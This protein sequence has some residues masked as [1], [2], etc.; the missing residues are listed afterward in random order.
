ME[1][2]VLSGTEL[3]GK[4]TSPFESGRFTA[5]IALSNAQQQTLYFNPSDTSYGSK[6]ID[7]MSF[8]F[9]SGDTFAG[10]IV[11]KTRK[12][13]KLF[14]A[15]PYYEFSW[16]D[17]LYFAYEVGFGSKGLFICLYDGEELIAVVDKQ[18]RVV[19]FKDTYTAYMANSKYTTIVIP[20]MIYYDVTAY[21]D[22]M[23]RAVLSVHKKNVTTLQKELI[24]K[25]D[26]DFIPR[27]K[28]L[29]GITD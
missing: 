29:E 19:N 16:N 3:V 21:G 23:E 18:L 13:G 5:Q 20:F 2:E 15:Y 27:I 9:F 28:V 24:A 7:R 12:T 8:K 14:G 10:K 6:L 1:W 4:A 25:Y 17:N 26:P 11:G 22:V